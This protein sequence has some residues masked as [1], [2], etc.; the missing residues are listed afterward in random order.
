MHVAGLHEHRATAGDA[1]DDLD[2]R[3][4]RRRRGPPRC[5]RYWNEPMTTSGRSQSQNRSVGGAAPRPPRRAMTSSRATCI[6]GSSV[7]GSMTSKSWS[8]H[9][10]ALPSARRTAMPMASGVKPMSETVSSSAP[11]IADASCSTPAS[12]DRPLSAALMSSR[13]VVRLEEEVAGDAHVARA[14]RRRRRDPL[15]RACHRE[16]CIRLSRLPQQFRMPLTSLPRRR[17]LSVGSSPS[18]P[19]SPERA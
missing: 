10:V 18:R 17:D 4:W 9:P 8:C 11:S 14:A 3:A 15:P 19:P 5:A 1:P 7:T 2:R 13:A 6:A 12:A 16:P